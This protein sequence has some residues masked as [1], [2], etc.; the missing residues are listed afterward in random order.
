MTK[1]QVRISSARS[2]GAYWRNGTPTLVRNTEEASLRQTRTPRGDINTAKR[3]WGG[4]GKQQQG[5]DAV[6]GSESLSNPD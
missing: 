5:W 2:G 1:P 6:L 4:A 3:H